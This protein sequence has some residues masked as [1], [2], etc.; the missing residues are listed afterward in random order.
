MTDGHPG[1]VLVLATLERYA[2][3]GRFYNLDL[4]G[5]REQGNVSPQELWYELD[6]AIVND[7]PEMLD[8]FAGRERERARRDMNGIIAWSLGMWCELLLRSWMTGVCGSLA[9]HWS[10]QLELGHP[11]PRSV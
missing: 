11:K 7:N 4:L 3:D 2:V 6:S 8:Q 5:G 10:P 9:Q 1:V